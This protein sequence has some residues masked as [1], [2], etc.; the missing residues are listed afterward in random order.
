M[1]ISANSE[2]YVKYQLNWL[3]FIFLFYRTFRGLE[4][5]RQLPSMF[6]AHTLLCSYI[7]AIHAWL[8]LKLSI[9]RVI[10]VP[11]PTP[12]EVHVYAWFQTCSFYPYNVILLCFYT[13][14]TVVLC[15]AFC[16]PV[17]HNRYHSLPLTLFFCAELLSTEFTAAV[18]WFN[19]ATDRTV[20]MN[21]IQC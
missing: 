5:V 6:T 14:N 21:A 19:F 15:A 12:G 20:N 2:P 10:I 4:G 16:M 3:C 18:D 7:A 9:F 1:Y 17:G 11:F 8:C 13:Y